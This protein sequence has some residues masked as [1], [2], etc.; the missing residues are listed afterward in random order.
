[1]T[2][3]ASIGSISHGTLN[4][5]DLIISFVD[6]LRRLEPECALV[7][8]ADAV[9]TLWAAGW[10]KIYDSEEAQELSSVLEEALSGHAPPNCYFGTHE[11]DASDFGFWPAADETDA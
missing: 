11:G 8:E 4:V 1:M 2:Y 3:K 5:A 7:K 6:E 10:A 9:Q